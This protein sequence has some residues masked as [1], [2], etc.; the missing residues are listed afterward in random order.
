MTYGGYIAIFGR[1]MDKHHYHLILQWRDEVVSWRATQTHS[2]KL[3]F[4]HMTDKRVDGIQHCYQRA[5]PLLSLLCI[6]PEFV[7]WGNSSKL[8]RWPSHHA[9]LQKRGEP[10][11]LAGGK[12]ATV[13]PWHNILH[14]VHRLCSSWQGGQAMCWLLTDSLAS[15][16]IRFKA[17]T[18][19]QHTVSLA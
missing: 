15:I 7:C 9:L 6:H 2:I 19:K 16:E 17:I 8:I 12:V 10:M 3:M 13:A 18:S 14:H 1:V 5:S 11:S 4:L